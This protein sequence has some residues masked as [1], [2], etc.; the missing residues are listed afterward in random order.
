MMFTNDK[1]EFDDELLTRYLLGELSSEEAER[2]DERSVA[3]DEFSWRLTAVE[4]DLVD[5][6]VSGELSGKVLERF[7]TFYLAS[8]KRREKVSFAQAI[9]KI[10][11][12]PP[13]LVAARAAASPSRESPK[14][15]KISFWRT[16]AMP[17]WRLQWGFA[18]AAVAMA[19]VAGFLF[20][21][22]GQLK[23]QVNGADSERAALDQRQQDLEK[24]LH[25]QRAA[26]AQVQSELERL[27]NQT[28]HVD[29]IKSIAVL[30][31]PQ[32]RG[33]GQPVSVSVPSGI[34]ALPV[35][36]QLESDEFHE[37]QVSLK[38]PGSDRAVWHS[39]K[40][41]SEAAG[42]IKSLFVSIPAK[43][44]RQQTYV[45]EATG[46]STKGTTEFISGYVFRVVLD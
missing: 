35:R 5:A 6:Y 20:V 31:M 10:G 17:Q 2:L 8:P 13:P 43:I 1:F 37:Y 46:I 30:L 16:L 45:L 38:E 11:N 33:V 25:E 15:E 12:E 27:R 34:D 39:A 14:P 19:M 7:K 3:D 29:T 36:L 40:L 41:K 22:V 32:T 9:L 24:Q 4:N 42:K 28:S 18:G 23:Q 26:S 21:E 44:L